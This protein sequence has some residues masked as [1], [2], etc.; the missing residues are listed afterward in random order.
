ML[1]K[2]A[3]HLSNQ[4]GNVCSWYPDKPCSDEDIYQNASFYMASNPDKYPW[5]SIPAELEEL[6][7]NM[8]RLELFFYSMFDERKIIWVD[9]CPF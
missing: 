5:D 2:E 3:K 9:E 8:H 1:Y 7:D 4:I 6:L